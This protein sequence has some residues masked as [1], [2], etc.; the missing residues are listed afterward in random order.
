MT[1]APS[2]RFSKQRNKLFKNFSEYNSNCL[3][4]PTGS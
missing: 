4:V 3:I 1:K 2:R